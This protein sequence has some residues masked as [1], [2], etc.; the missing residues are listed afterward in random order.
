[1]LKDILA[2][3]GQPGLFKMVSKGNNSVIVESLI[4]GKRFPAHST[5]KVISLED[6][7]I[8]TETE[9][10]PLVQVMK[11]IADK[12]EFKASIDHK[13]SSKVLKSYFTEV[14]PDFDEDRV[15]VSD[16]KKVIQWYNILQ[17][18]DMLN[19]D[20]VANE[21]EATESEEKE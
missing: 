7:A 5:N 15:Y 8:Y 4:N 9:E 20:E 13:S 10:V 19:F 11:K 21:E 17:Q 3:S 6:I 14:L 12:E 18:K 16:I 2:I 1:M